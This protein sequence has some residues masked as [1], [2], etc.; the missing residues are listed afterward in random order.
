M[1]VQ[2]AKTPEEYVELVNQAI[3]EI[4]ELRMAAEY[5]MD[6][7]G[8]SM[9]FVD[10][11][12]KRVRA[13]KASMEDGTYAFGNRDLPF[14]EIVNKH[15]TDALPF[16]YLLRVINETHRKGLDVEEI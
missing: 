13:L 1:A 5:D 12:E 2:R 6:D 16:R 11:L 4:E 3:F 10:D 9:A 7:L 15:D 14:M 8:T